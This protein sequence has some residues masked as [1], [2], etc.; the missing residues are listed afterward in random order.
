MN[1]QGIYLNP[2]SDPKEIL[3]TYFKDLDQFLHL[4]DPP[5]YRK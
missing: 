2:K 5:Y 3:E 4:A 1:H